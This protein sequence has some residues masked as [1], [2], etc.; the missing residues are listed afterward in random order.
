MVFHVVCVTAYD[1]E[2]LWGGHY[3]SMDSSTT[4]LKSRVKMQKF[5]LF[6]SPGSVLV[7]V[8][9]VTVLFIISIWVTEENLCTE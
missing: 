7:L 9:Y 3:Y 2:G 1:L 5:I 4:G 6:Y 8:S